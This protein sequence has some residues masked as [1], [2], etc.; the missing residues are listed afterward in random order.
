MSGEHAGQ[1]PYETF[2][3]PQALAIY[4]DGAYEWNEAIVL[5]DLIRALRTDGASDEAD[6]M[7]SSAISANPVFV[8]MPGRDGAQAIPDED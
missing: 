1:H 4:R 3:T 2:G 7:E 6:R 5:H 8:R